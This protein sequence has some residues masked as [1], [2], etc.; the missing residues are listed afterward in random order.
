MRASEQSQKRQVTDTGFPEN[1]YC[2][3]SE[4]ELSESE[5]KFR[6]LVEATSDWIWQVNQNGVY[7]YVSPKVKDILGFEPAE[8]LGKTP[9]DLM[10]KS[11]AEKI[12]KIF[13]IIIKNKRP[14]FNLENWAVHKNG[15]LV[16]LETSGVPVK[17]EKGQLVGYRGIDRDITE[18]KK[19]EDALKESEQLY[20]TLFDN[21]DDGFLIV[22]PIYENSVMNFRF[23]KVNQVYERQTGTK[24]DDV[25]GKRAREV[26]PELEPNMFL[27]TCEV[28]KTGKSA[29]KEEHNRYSNKWYDSY[30]F[31]FT[32]GKVGILFRDIT[33]R[34]K[35]EAALRS[36]EEKYRVYVESSPVAFF[37]INSEQK[38]V[39]VNDK[40]C[41]LLGYSEK[42]L[43]EMAISDIVFEEDLPL[44]RKQYFELEETGK[45][46]TEFRLKRKDGQ[47]VY[48]ILNAT[49]L[50]DGKAMAFC[51]DITERKKLEKRLQSN[52]RMA[53]IGATAGMVGHDI[54]NPLQAM[55]SDI[56]LLKSELASQLQG[57]A[58]ENVAES[59]DSLENN[60]LYINK[61]V[62]DLQDYSRTLKPEFSSVDLSDVIVSAFNTINIADNITLSVKV[63]GLPSLRTDPA[64][65]QRV[66]TNL[67]NN[68]VQAMPDGGKLGVEGFIKER[69]IY[70]TV[71]DTG[72]G[73]SEEVK[74]K[75]FEP[76]FTTKAKGQ[77]LGLAVAK[78][79]TNALNGTITFESEEGKGTKFI[80]ELPLVL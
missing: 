57:E 52:E 75:L 33:E 26:V 7:T 39:Q 18:R 12:L 48:V 15:N 31:R 42:E 5:E 24:T 9:F 73:I 35:A 27:L 80:I 25:L 1:D 10:P 68:A 66:L 64:L 40:A 2:R 11:E 23:L 53:A 76:M 67:V 29:R 70:I 13:N 22:E 62:A 8:V 46:I 6:S 74:S 19:I 77:G 30:Y 47:P 55:M 50:S 21:S 69:K 56:F 63:K 61:I 36:S 60:I 20:Q 58:K 51:E 54:R 45:S 65:I 32:E 41:K 3:K 59:L 71:S 28:A 44:V 16:L 49:M 34:K 43:L 72:V 17:D 4:K 14:F 78:R 37:V 79:I 38:Y